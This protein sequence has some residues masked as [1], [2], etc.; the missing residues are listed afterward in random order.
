[1]RMSSKSF[2]LQ[3]RIHSYV[4]DRMVIGTKGKVQ[5]RSVH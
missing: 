5:L 4:T 1:M 3:A 2:M